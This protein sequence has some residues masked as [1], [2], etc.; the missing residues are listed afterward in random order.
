MKSGISAGMGIRIDC[1]QCSFTASSSQQM[2][3]HKQHR[4]EGT[5]RRVGKL[6][7][8]YCDYRN[9]YRKVMDL[10]IKAHEGSLRSWVVM[11]STPSPHPTAIIAL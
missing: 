5:M 7:C 1:D 6:S 8:P 10:H 9:S 2:L 3:K 11:Y 4:H